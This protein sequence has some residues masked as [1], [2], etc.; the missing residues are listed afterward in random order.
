MSGLLV[1][2]LNKVFLAI[3]IIETNQPLVC[4]SLNDIIAYEKIARKK[5]IFNKE[6]KT[7]ILSINTQIV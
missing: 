5:A 2:Y 1:C 4:Y 7:A 6:N 3:V